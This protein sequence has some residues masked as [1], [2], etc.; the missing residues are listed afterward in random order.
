MKD[1]G[2]PSFKSAMTDYICSAISKAFNV[3]IEYNHNE[4][5]TERQANRNAKAYFGKY[6]GVDWNSKYD[7]DS[8]IENHYP[9][10]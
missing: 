8:T 10:W 6:Y 2:I 5:W 7:E 9:T 3:S 1:I 4:F